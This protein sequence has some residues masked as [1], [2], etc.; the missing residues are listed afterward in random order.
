MR[1]GLKNELE[2][3]SVHIF[4]ELQNSYS[5]FEHCN[6]LVE[7]WKVP[8]RKVISTVMMTMMKEGRIIHI[9]PYQNN[10]ESVDQNILIGFYQNIGLDAPGRPAIVL[11]PLFYI[12]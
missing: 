11:N 7:I 8:P 5:N 6:A 12:Q 1:N 2:S 3:E 10:W 9:V 4:L